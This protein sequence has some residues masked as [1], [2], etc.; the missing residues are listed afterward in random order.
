[1]TSHFYLCADLNDYAIFRDT[2]FLSLFLSFEIQESNYEDHILESI[3]EVPGPL[4]MTKNFSNVL[5]L[6]VCSFIG[7]WFLEV[8]EY[9]ITSKVMTAAMYKKCTNYKESNKVQQIMDYG[10]MERIDNMSEI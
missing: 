10:S 9:G 5:H 4:T 7:Y 8:V 3:L 2:A 6:L 1:M